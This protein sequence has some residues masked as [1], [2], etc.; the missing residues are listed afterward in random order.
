MSM[1]VSPGA[2]VSARVRSASPRSSLVMSRCVHGP[3]DVSSQVPSGTFNT[4]TW[5]PRPIR[6]TG[7]RRRGAERHSVEWSLLQ[8]LPPDD[9]R[10]LLDAASPRH[11]ARGEVVFHEGDTGDTLHL[12][13]AGRAAVRRQR[14]RARSRR[15]RSSA[16]GSSSASRRW[17]TTAASGWRRVSALEALDTLAV[18]RHVFDELRLRH[19]S[20]ERLLVQALA[21][22]V[23]W[24]R[25]RLLEALF[26]PAD[27]R[28]VRGLVV[29]AQQYA[30]DASQE[31]SGPH[32]PESPVIVPL[33]QEDLASLAGTTPAGPGGRAA[34]APRPGQDRGP[35]PVRPVRPRRLGHPAAAVVG[36]QRTVAGSKALTDGSKAPH[37]ITNSW[38]RSRFRPLY[39]ARP[40][41][42]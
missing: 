19:P 1:E 39:R 32:Q 6:R 25:A 34:G 21:G 42:L 22:Q 18:R 38:S 8:S 36:G 3:S 26:L 13:T 29:L 4:A 41:S 23:R 5:R 15:S 35:R 9:R 24:L 37:P 16:L 33:T 2:G 40:P 10:G 7:R 20:V 14:Q 12:I 31:M 28:V 11:F 17:R 27:K 30:P